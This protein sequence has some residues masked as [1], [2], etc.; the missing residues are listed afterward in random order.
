MIG[1][2]LSSDEFTSEFE[3][4]RRDPFSPNSLPKGLSETSSFGGKRSD[5]LL[6]DQKKGSKR[7]EFG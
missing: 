1:I 4:S 6:G 3:M 2:D 5:V 7:V